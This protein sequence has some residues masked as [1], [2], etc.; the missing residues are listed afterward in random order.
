MPSSSVE[1]VIALRI[2]KPWGQFIWKDTIEIK[3][4]WNRYDIPY[5]PKQSEDR[6]MLE[7]RILNKGFVW[8]DQIQWVESP[9]IETRGEIFDTVM[10]MHAQTIAGLYPLKNIHYTYFPT[11]ADTIYSG[12]LEKDLALN[13]AGYCEVAYPLDNGEVQKIP[14]PVRLGY[15]KIPSLQY[16][17]EPSL[18]YLAGGESAL[19]DGVLG[20]FVWDGKWQ[21]FEGVD[22]EGVISVPAGKSITEVEL[23]A[24]S[25]KSAWVYWP[26]S[27]EIWGS[28]DGTQFEPLQTI[29]TP[30]Q[31]YAAP[32]GVYTYHLTE[33]ISS[34]AAGK[35]WKYFKIKACSI[36]KLPIDHPFVGEKS[37]LFIDEILLH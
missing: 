25:K 12:N 32:E 35:T 29:T 4:G 5:F 6:N 27:V 1:N 3:S 9:T 34:D 37:W 19:I 7:L 26:Q 36:K 2:E 24:L 31:A 10:Y 18:K 14:F 16:D 20:E 23:R 22:F 17:Q 11:G 13:Y 33:K 30:D 21:G 15:Y 8:L 28:H